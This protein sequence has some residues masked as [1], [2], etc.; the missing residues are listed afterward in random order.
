VALS[1]IRPGAFPP[2]G[3]V[4]SLSAGV[5]GTPSQA[6]DLVWEVANRFRFFKRSASFDMQERAFAAARGDVKVPIPDKIIWKTERRLNDP[7]CK[8]AS[9]PDACAATARARYE[10]SRQGWAAQT[11]DFT[12]FDRNARP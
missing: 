6:S 8:D 1:C 7:D 11:V 12:C 2:R 10:T 3:C 5:S 4:V 9:N